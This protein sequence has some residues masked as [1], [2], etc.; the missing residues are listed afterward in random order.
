MSGRQFAGLA[1]LVSLAAFGLG[2]LVSELSVKLGWDQPG[3][4]D[5]RDQREVQNE[6]V[7]E[8]GASGGCSCGLGGGASGSTSDGRSSD[9]DACPV[10][11]D[12][13]S[14]TPTETVVGA[15][16]TPTATPTSVCVCG[17]TPTPDIRTS[18]PTA[19]PRHTQE[20]TPTATPRPTR[21][22]TDVP[23]ATST[24]VPTVG[25]TGTSTELPT[26]TAV[27]K[28][29]CNKGGGNGSE[30]CDPGNNPEEGNDDEGEGGGH[31]H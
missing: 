28:V 9:W 31:G 13:P 29:K 20:A 23:T 7:R 15:C 1:V 21:G 27:P 25:P 30:G 10:Y 26:A 14:V 4:R 24:P 22:P 3:W 17:A 2:A 11:P 5:Q 12:V 16:E 18:I 6:L 19:T 8:M